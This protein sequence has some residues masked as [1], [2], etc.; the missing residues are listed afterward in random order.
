[1]TTLL[2][3]NE[4][5]HDVMKIIKSLEGAGLLIKVLVKQLKMNQN[6]KNMDFSAYC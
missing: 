3:I 6:N 2:I 5:I 1:M 4:E